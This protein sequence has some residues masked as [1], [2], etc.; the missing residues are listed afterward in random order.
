M[1]VT[2]NDMAMCITPPADQKLFGE[3]L[4]F[5]DFFNLQA[6]VSKQTHPLEIDNLVTNM[7]KTVY[8]A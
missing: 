6:N 3:N 2:G 5:Q 1:E 7:S 4:A 8:E